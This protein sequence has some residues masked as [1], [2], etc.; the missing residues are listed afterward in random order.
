MLRRPGCENTHNFGVGMRRTFS[1]FYNQFKTIVEPLFPEE[2][3]FTRDELVHAYSLLLT[4][5]LVLRAEFR[6]RAAQLGDRRWHW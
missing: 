4:A 5:G 1:K 2:L 3:G 6:L